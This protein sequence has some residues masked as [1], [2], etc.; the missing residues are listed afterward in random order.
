MTWPSY[1]GGAL[2]TQTCQE[3]GFHRFGAHTKWIDEDQRIFI[4][5]CRKCSYTYI[6]QIVLE[7]RPN[8][9]MTANVVKL[10]EGN[11]LDNDW[12]DG[13]LSSKSK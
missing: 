1:S 4:R 7:N 11:G 3:L 6:A 9:K 13:M 2:Q 12:D 5:G 8:S 10:N